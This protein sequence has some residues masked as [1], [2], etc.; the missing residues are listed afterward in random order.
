MIPVTES[1]IKTYFLSQYR[2]LFQTALDEIEERFHVDEAI[3]ALEDVFISY[4]ETEASEV[5]IRI[6]SEVFTADVDDKALRCE[7]KTVG[8]IESHRDECHVLDFVSEFHS[9]SMLRV[10]LPNICS[11]LLM[12]LIQ[13]S[14]ACTADLLY[15]EEAENLP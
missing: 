3:V 7:V 14:T 2:A 10:V 12:L 1:D 11:C 15:Y 8:L 9:D 5:A 6:V 13:A 4:P